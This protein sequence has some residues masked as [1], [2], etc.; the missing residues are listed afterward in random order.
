MRFALDRYKAI[1]GL[2]A[3]RNLPLGYVKI[4]DA[5]VRPACSSGAGSVDR[6]HLSWLVEVCR[7]CG[8]ATQVDDESSV[9]TLRSLGI[10]YGQGTALN[11]LGPLLT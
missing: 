10:D 2:Q 8:I 9:D 1:G 7:A 4:H 5:L 6:L 3:L 11:K